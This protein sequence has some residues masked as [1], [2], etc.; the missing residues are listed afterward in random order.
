MLDNELVMEGGGFVCVSRKRNWER[1]D[2]EVNPVGARDRYKWVS[3][4]NEMLWGL[5]RTL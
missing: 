4:F 5:R 1:S 3:S 2:E